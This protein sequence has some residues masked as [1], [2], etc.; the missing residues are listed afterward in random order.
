M[1][2][3]LF[4]V[5]V[6][7]YLQGDTLLH[8]CIRHNYIGTCNL[9]YQSSDETSLQQSLLTKGFDGKTPIELTEM[10]RMN[11]LSA[12]FKVCITKFQ[13]VLS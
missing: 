2:N 11:G 5:C 13:H 4:P 3:Y 12:L 6:G 9:I 1:H 7:Q 8:F 10:F